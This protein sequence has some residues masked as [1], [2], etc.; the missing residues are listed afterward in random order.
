MR[1]IAAM[2]LGLL[3]TTGCAT[4]TEQRRV[5]ERAVRAEELAGHYRA[6]AGQAETQLG[7]AR[8]EL[9]RAN[10]RARP[11][12]KTCNH[13]PH[14]PKPPASKSGAIDEKR[15]RTARPR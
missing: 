4:R 3:V 10:E 2:T 1:L 12:Q 15:S 11:A 6:R 9:R 8:A 7:Q 13:K 14:A 5:S